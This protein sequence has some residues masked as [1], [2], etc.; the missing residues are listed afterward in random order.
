MI[1]AR[2]AL[3]RI[4]DDTI[5]LAATAVSQKERTIARRPV[6]ERATDTVSEKPGAGA[7]VVI[8]VR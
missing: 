7:H 1:V 6:L 8:G 4:V 2:R 3:A 5:I